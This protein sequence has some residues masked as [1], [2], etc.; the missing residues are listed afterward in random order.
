MKDERL[1]TLSIKGLHLEV[2]IGILPIEREVSQGLIVNAS[3]E[4]LYENGDFLD[5]MLV[6]Q[7]IASLLWNGRYGLLEDAL[8]EVAL[9]LFKAHPKV[10]KIWLEFIKPGVSNRAQIGLSASFSRE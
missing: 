9:R 10:Q 2:L 5:Y 6:S 7:E 8:S 1:R 3:L 4:Y